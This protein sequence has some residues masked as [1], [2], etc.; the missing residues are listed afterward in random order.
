MLLLLYGS[1]SA[2]FV[3]AIAP[4]FGSASQA[5]NYVLFIFLLG[6]LLMMASSVM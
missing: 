6:A 4:M 3:Y 1:A 5:Q 2:S